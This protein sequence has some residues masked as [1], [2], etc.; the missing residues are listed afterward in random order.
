MG[1][2]PLAL[3]LAL[4]VEVSWKWKL[5][6]LAVLA[7]TFLV[8]MHMAGTE[9]YVAARIGAIIVQILLAITY[10]IRRQLPDSAF[11]L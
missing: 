5:I 1:L 8:P 10:L 3:C 4:V 9:H 6:L 7:G 2:I 11:R